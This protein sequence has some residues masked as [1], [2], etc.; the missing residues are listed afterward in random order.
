MVSCHQCHMINGFKKVPRECTGS[1]ASSCVMANATGGKADLCQYQYDAATAT[2]EVN[3]LV[4][5][6]TNTNESETEEGFASSI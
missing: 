2:A 1:S 4:E 5:G 6:V 3:C